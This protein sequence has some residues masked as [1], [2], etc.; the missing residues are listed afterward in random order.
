MEE[1]GEEEE[2]SSTRKEKM[3][4]LRK[5]IVKKKKKE[6]EEE[7]SSSCPESAAVTAAAFVAAAESAAVCAAATAAAFVSPRVPLQAGQVMAVNKTTRHMQLRGLR[8]LEEVE[9]EMKKAADKRL[10]RNGAF[11]LAAEGVDVDLFKTKPAKRA[12]SSYKPHG[13]L[14]VW[15]EFIMC[16]IWIRRGLDKDI[17][18]E[19][20]L[21]ATGKNENKMVNSVL[22]TWVAALYEFLRVEEWW[23]YPDEAKE[24]HSMAFSGPE[25][26]DFTKV[27]DCSNVNCE[28]GDV[29]ELLRPQL[30]STYY[31]NPCGKYLFVMSKIGGTELVSPGMGGPASDHEVMEASG[32]YDKTLWAVPGSTWTPQMLYDAGVTHRTKTAARAVGFKMNTSGIVRKSKKNALSA[33]QRSKNFR[34]SSVRIRVENFIGIVKQRFKI[35][36][37][38]LRQTDLGMMDKIVYICFMLHN[39]GPAIV[40]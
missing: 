1:E 7:S 26:T 4:K 10:G 32:L 14:N 6:E 36:K 12:L 25:A 21:G 3:T 19:K 39:F 23:M 29:D 34:V 17:I 20:F 16:M 37:V 5:K 8:P 33:A 40:K 9:R 18:A 27:G 24:L 13:D 38:P 15:Q 30:W 28:A 2:G 11:R 35:L 22:R 31:N